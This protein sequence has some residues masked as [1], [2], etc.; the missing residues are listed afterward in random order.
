MFSIDNNSLKH[1]TQLSTVP[2]DTYM[3]NEA[4]NYYEFDFPYYKQRKVSGKP[5]SEHI[6]QSSCNL[7]QLVD[8]SL[9][10]K[11]VKNRAR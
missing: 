3:V 11:S 4:E 2:E 9:Q 8:I 5:K 1:N 6:D 7:F 10:P